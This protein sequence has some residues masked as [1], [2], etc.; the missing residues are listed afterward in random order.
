LVARHQ[1]LEAGWPADRPLLL[2][3]PFDTYGLRK[4]VDWKPRLDGFF[5]GTEAPQRR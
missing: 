1:R 4:E 3:T 5:M 2:C